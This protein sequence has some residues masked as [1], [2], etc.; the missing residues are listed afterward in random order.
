[1]YIW[2]F[3]RYWCIDVRCIHHEKKY[4]GRYQA[5][6]RYCVNPF[7]TY[8]IQISKDLRNVDEELALFLNILPGQKL[9]KQCKETAKENMKAAKNDCENDK[10]EQDSSYLLQAD[11]IPVLKH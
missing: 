3:V 10:D 4:I 1:M 9:C 6:Q 2:C 8:G 11:S 5:T 7:N